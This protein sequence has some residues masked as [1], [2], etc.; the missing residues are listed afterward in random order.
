MDT[1]KRKYCVKWMEKGTNVIRISYFHTRYIDSFANK[2][3]AI[4]RI[5]VLTI[6]QA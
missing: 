2:L 1:M 3:R 6:H 5:T 4:S